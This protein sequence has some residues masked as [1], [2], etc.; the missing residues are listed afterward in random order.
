MQSVE[1]Q[2]RLGPN[3]LANPATGTLKLATSSTIVQFLGTRIYAP[4]GTSQ[5]QPL[6]RY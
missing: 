6:R 1:I 2:R 4:G 5:Y 3:C